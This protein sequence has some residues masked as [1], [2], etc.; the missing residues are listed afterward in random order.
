MITSVRLRNWKSHD[1]TELEFD[2]GTN[3]LVGVMGSGK[4]AVLDAITYGLFGTVPNVRNRTIKLDD[5]IKKRP[6][7]EDKAEV[8]IGFLTPNEEEYRVKRVLERGEGTVMAELRK[9][10][11]DLINKPQSTAVTED[12]TSLLK[13]DYEFFERMIY[14]EQNQLDRFLTLEPRKRRKKVDEL[15]KINKFEKARKNITT[16]TNRLSDRRKDRLEDIQELKKDEDIENLPSLEEEL[17]KTKSEREE[18]REELEELAPKLEG[19]KEELQ[20]FED[21]KKELEKIAKKVESINGKLEAQENQIDK[22]KDKLGESADKDLESLEKR[23][24]NIEE[25]LENRKSRV[26]DLE[27]EN[28]S[29]TAKVSELET[30]LK[31][32]RS[33]VDELEEEIGKKEEYK[34]ELEEIEVSTLEDELEDLNGEREKLK[35][36]LSE[37]NVVVNNL[38]ES[39]SELREAESVCPT[40]GRDLSGEKKDNLIENREKK[41]EKTK[42]EIDVLDD[43]ISS[44]E[45]KIEERKNL[46]EKARDFEKEIADLPNLRKELE[47]LEERISDKSDLL[48]EASKKQEEVQENLE[49]EKSQVNE[50]RKRYEDVKDM[51]NLKKDLKS[52][53]GDKKELEEKKEK[54]EKRLDEK[55]EGY[56]EDKYKK[57]KN[58]HEDIIKRQEHLKTRLS[59]INKLIK[60]K[61]KLIESIRKKKETLERRKAE[62]RVLEESIDSLKTVQDAMSKSQTTLRNQVIEAVNGMMN[63][64]WDDIYPYGDFPKIRLSIEERRKISD[65][66]LQVLDSSGSWVSVEGITSGGERTCALLALRIAFAVVLSPGLSWLVLD[67]PT[68]NL[69]KEGID[70]L[71]EILRNRVPK[72]V[73]QLLLITHEERLESAVSGNLYRFHRDKERDE[74]TQVERVYGDE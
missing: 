33:D 17:E 8:E 57:L 19:V 34:E 59:E 2:E 38:K 64:M 37:K 35:N 58:R 44:V 54:F 51:V 49:E 6:V 53:I 48:E 52:S 27:S 42:S 65:Y 9:A 46:V 45:E 61:K 60:E 5:L 15:L 13:L 62:T 1:E 66:E 7:E 67:E 12:I 23:A 3:V 68:H 32:L 39:L 72:I 56:D 22:L 41:L 16:L 71:S 30:E 26:E 21:V 70:Q 20:D 11:G 50:L 4:S 43:D 24:E 40:C 10:D 25:D 29:L 14:A 31:N 55:K 28:Q 63:D 74:P 36:S 47:K 73:K 18:V 69:D